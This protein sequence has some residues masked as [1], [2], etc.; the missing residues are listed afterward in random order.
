MQKHEYEIIVLFS[1]VFMHIL[2]DYKLQ[3][4]LAEM[5]QIT[6]WFHNYPQKKYEN[7]YITALIE[8]AFSWTFMVHIP[9]TL[10]FIIS[11]RSI[12]ILLLSFILNLIVHTITDH[13]KANWSAINL[14]QDQFIHIMQILYTWYFLTC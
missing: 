3:G 13:A 12:D 10:F 8:H 4:I 6:W 5:K 2:D 1:M 9:P 7:D 14:T 11:N